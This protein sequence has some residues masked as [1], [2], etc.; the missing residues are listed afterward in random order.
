MSIWALGMQIPA[1]CPC[2]HPS[3]VF[4][5]ELNRSKIVANTYQNNVSQHLDHVQ[6]ALFVVYCVY[7]PK[8]NYIHRAD[9]IIYNS[10][11][12]DDNPMIAQCCGSAKMIL[13]EYVTSNEN[14]CANFKRQNLLSHHLICKGVFVLGLKNV[15]GILCNTT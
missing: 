12:P 2:K 8:C 10:S 5:R 4:A 13:Y 6:S 14:L 1:T 11:L 7:A 9:R 15:Q 3:T